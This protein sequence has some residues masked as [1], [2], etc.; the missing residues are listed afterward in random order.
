[1]LD[2]E[3]S[4]KRTCDGVVTATD[5]TNV[6]SGSWESISLL[7]IEELGELDSPPVQVRSVGI[8][9]VMLKSSVL[10]CENPLTP[11]TLLATERFVWPV[12]PREFP[13]TQLDIECRSILIASELTCRV[14]VTDVRSSSVGIYLVDGDGHSSAFKL[15][16]SACII[17]KDWELRQCFESKSLIVQNV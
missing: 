3:A 15:L 14:H 11:G 16:E 9:T 10:A 8:V 7:M 12:A 13:G 6:A 4:S 17:Q 1:M 2:G 5:C